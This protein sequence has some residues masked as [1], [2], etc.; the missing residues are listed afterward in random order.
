MDQIRGIL[1]RL[2][3]RPRAS[4]TTEPGSQTL[5]GAPAVVAVVEPPPPAN[6]GPFVWLVIAAV[7]VLWL[8]RDVLGPFIV[9]AVVAYAFSP[10]V[11]AGQRTGWPRVAVVGL[12]YAIAVAIIAPVVYLLAGRI[13][14]EISML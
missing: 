2:L 11:A 5:E 4:E 8:A 7:V 1:S 10:L 3:G 6:R 9:A 13:A 12:G 14:H